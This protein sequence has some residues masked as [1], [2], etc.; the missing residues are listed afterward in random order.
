[1]QKRY[2][3]DANGVPEDDILRRSPL[4]ISMALDP[5]YKSL[6][7]LQIAEKQ[8]IVHSRIKMLLQSQP[9]STSRVTEPLVKKAKFMD[10]LM[11]DIESVGAHALA[12]D[13]YAEF[14]QE[15]VHISEPLDWWKINAYKYPS[16]AKL[17]KTYLCIPATSVPSERIFSLAGQTVSKLRAS[18]DP[19]TVNEIIFM[20]KHLKPK[21]TQLLEEFDQEESLTDVKNETTDSGTA[22]TSNTL[23]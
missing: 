7:A 20:N 5:R 23:F 1:M 13:E 9:Q 21:I 6:R 15:K 14:L 12:E 17:S 3:I 22:T 16:L 10:C 8:E 18:L 2:H 11:G 19:D 4:I